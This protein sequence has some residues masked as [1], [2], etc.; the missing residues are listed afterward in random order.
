[1]HIQINWLQAAD[2]HP[3]DSEISHLS[4]IEIKLLR[5]RPSVISGEITP[6]RRI[7]RYGTPAVQTAVPEA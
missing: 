2:I 7:V 1:M 4:D 5:E 3:A 6:L